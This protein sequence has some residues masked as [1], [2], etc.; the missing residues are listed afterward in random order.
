MIGCHDLRECLG[1]GAIRLVATRA[2]DGSVGQ[3]RR[4]RSRI[5]GVLALCSV[6]RFAGNVGVAAKLFLI[7]DLGVAALTDVVTSKNRRTGRDLSDRCP[8]VVAILAKALGH[9]GGTQQ[10]KNRQ[11]DDNDDR[12]TDEMFSVLEHVRFPAPEPGKLLSRETACDLGYRGGGT[13]D[14]EWNHRRA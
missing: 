12:K 5:V 9:D 14:D 8:A 10:N 6:A 3:L 2:D 4:H 1:L 11:E 7:D 13:G